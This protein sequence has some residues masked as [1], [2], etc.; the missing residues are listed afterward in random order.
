MRHAARLEDHGASRALQAVAAA[1]VVILAL[2][3]LTRSLQK[4]PPPTEHRTQSAADLLTVGCLNA[5]CR[6]G[7]LEELERQCEEAAQ[8]LDQRPERT[9]VKELIRELKG[10]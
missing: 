10:T 7:G 9:S 5:A 1:A 3:I 4:T 2:I 6:R 8:R